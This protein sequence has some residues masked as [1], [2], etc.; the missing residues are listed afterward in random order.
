MPGSATHAV[1][2]AF[3][4]SGKY[5]ARRLLDAGYT[6]RTLTGSPN[7]ENP[8]AGR[9]QP[10]PY[11]FDAP[12]QLV[13]ALRGV[14]VLYNTYWVRFNYNGDTRFSH[15]A[16]VGNT[17]K[18][19]DAARTAGVRR[20]VHVSITNPSEDSP[21]EYFRGKA[22]IERGLIESGLSYAL[23]RPTVLFGEEDVLINN[24]AW[25]LRHFPIFGVFGDGSYM[26]QPIYVDDLA[27]LAVE[28]G[29]STE[30]RILDTVGPETFTYR[31]LVQV[32]GD[33]IGKP[34]P[35][36]QVSPFAG[37]MLAGLIG[38]LVGDVVITPE[39]I[40][41]LMAGLLV[42]QSPPLGQVRLTDWARANA[43]ALGRHYANELSR[44]RDRRTAYNRL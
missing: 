35:I 19:F 31:G 2:G 42:T 32:I 5:I 11:S 24:I 21:Y 20:I 36:I 8:F 14:D 7:R 1:T 4:Y 37:R 34:R 17:L 40:E 15:E 25:I 29:A 10:F 41:A 30:N 6:V 26:L 23:L 39:E 44:R 22:Q 33:L 38:R 18:L 16:A 28:Q 13:D 27:G 43:G 3:G 9:V 12:E